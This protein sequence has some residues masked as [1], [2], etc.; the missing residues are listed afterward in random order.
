MVAEKKPS[1]VRREDKLEK[2]SRE[3]EHNE[4]ESKQKRK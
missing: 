2:I 4:M 3:I 1:K